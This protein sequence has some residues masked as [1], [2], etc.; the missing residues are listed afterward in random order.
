MSHKKR[1]TS[2]WVLPDQFVDLPFEE[3]RPVEEFAKY[4]FEVSNMGRIRHAIGGSV[5]L[6]HPNPNE[7]GYLK[8]NL[9]VGR[10]CNTRRFHILVAKAFVERERP[11]QTCVNHIDGDKTNCRADNLEW[12]TYGENSQ[13]ARETGLLD[14]R[15]EVNDDERAAILWELDCGKSATSIAR[16][17]GL[18]GQTV[19][20]IRNRGWAALKLVE[21]DL[22]LN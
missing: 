12:C 19:Y 14:K 6:L 17:R 3:W 18:R 8:V 7:N 21:D 9:Y 4:G 15:R 11:E 1:R 5:H 22:I 20:N 10:N 16:A 13:H 2:R